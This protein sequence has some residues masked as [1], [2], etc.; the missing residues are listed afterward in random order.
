MTANDSSDHPT[1]N[2]EAGTHTTV[3]C[4]WLHVGSGDAHLISLK[5]VSL[6]AG[7]DETILVL[8]QRAQSALGVGKGR[9]LAWSG[10]IL[11][12]AAT[13][14]ER[15]QHPE[16]LTR[17]VRHVRIAASMVFR[18]FYSKENASAAIL[19]DGSAVSRGCAKFGG[20]SGGVRDQLQRVPRKQELCQGFRCDP[21]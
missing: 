12:G 1:S 2:K 3:P 14:R 10:E 21:R 19:G 5:T 7:A 11:D 9:Q 16:V 15:L 17:Q 8:S 20:D 13:P 18:S 6:E 4:S